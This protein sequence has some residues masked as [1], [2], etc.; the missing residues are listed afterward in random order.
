MH[1]SMN[2]GLGEQCLA[3]VPRYDF[4]YQQFFFYQDPIVVPPGPGGTFTISCTYDT[5]GETQTT[6]WGEGTND[7]MCI[8]ALYVTY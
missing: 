6:H 5:R 4:G 7:E 1:L 3:D 2:L 8:A